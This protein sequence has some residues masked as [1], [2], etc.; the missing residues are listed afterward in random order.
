MFVDIFFVKIFYISL[1]K[2]GFEFLGELGVD[3]VDEIEIVLL[4]NFM[5]EEIFV[6]QVQDINIYYV[7]SVYEFS[8]LN[9]EFVDQ[10]CICDVWSMLVCKYVVLCS[11]FI[12]SIFENGLFDQFVFKKILLNMFFFDS[13]NIEEM[14]VSFFVMKV[15]CGQ[16]CYRLSVICSVRRIFVCLDVSQVIIDS[17]SIVNLVFQFGQVYVGEDIIVD[18]LFFMIYFYNILVD[19]VSYLQFVI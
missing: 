12:D 19:L 10:G 8:M 4:I 13:V 11:I 16:F 14:F 1:V 6:V 3:S 5:Q 7:C 17:C 18:C 15:F 9:G 2:F